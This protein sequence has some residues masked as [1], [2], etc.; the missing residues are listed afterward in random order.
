MNKFII[1]EYKTTGIKP[2][3]HKH[4]RMFEAEHGV[5]IEMDGGF[6]RHM[7]FPSEEAYTMALLKWL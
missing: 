4:K 1:D 6:W 5:K 7:E 3:I 2:S